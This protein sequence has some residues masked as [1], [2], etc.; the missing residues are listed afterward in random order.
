MVLQPTNTA[1]PS[2]APPD[3]AEQPRHMLGRPPSP[4]AA[5]P[6]NSPLP[7]AH[8]H[9]RQ[10]PLFQ[11]RL[12]RRGY[13]IGLLVIGISANV[14]FAAVALVLNS[15]AHGDLAKAD[16]STPGFLVW[17]GL[18]FI[19]PGFVH[20]LVAHAVGV[21]RM[22]DNQQY[23]DR[24]FLFYILGIL[25]TPIQLFLLSGDPGPNRYGPPMTSRNLLDVLGFRDGRATGPD[26][27]S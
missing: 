20:L 3:E 27:R 18:A 21:R 4:P 10:I 6:G 23:T 25:P 12:D 2:E 16:K 14:W 9:A 8:H 24:Q 7:I 15:L 11:G 19:I 26:R 1:P 13:M 5:L 17:H 22:H